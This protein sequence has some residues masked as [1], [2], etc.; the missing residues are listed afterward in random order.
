MAIW[1]L[2]RLRTQ[3]SQSV[4]CLIS[5]SLVL[6]GC[7]QYFWKAFGTFKNL[8]SDVSK[9]QHQQWDCYT[10]QQEGKEA[11][12]LLAFPLDLWGFIIWLLAGMYH[13]S[14]GRTSPY[15]FLEMP[16][17]TSPGACYLADSRSIKVNNHIYRLLYF[18]FW[19]FNSF[20]CCIFIL[21]HNYELC[22]LS[23]ISG[24]RRT[25]SKNYTCMCTCLCQKIIRL[26]KYSLSF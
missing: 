8:G 18:V 14:D 7:M 5:L 9:G 3:F 21:R 6:K 22:N 19:V 1:I 17:K 20:D 25:V 23:H 26:S 24:C 15:F 10:H 12:K 13:P 16:S 11:E 2:E 4:W